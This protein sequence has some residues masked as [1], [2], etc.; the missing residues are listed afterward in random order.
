VVHTT[1]RREVHE[2]EESAPLPVADGPAA[3]L[4]AM[5]SPSDVLRLQ[6]AIG[7]H[8]TGTLLGSRMLLRLGSRLDKPL[9]RGAPKP[10]RE[11]AGQ[12]RRYSVAQYIKMWEREQGRKITPE[13]RETIERGCIGLTADNL[14]GGGNPPL[15]L[16]FSTFE[17][18]HNDGRQEQDDGRAPRDPVRQG[19][20]LDDVRK[21]LLV[22]P[23]PRSEDAQ[24][25]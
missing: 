24:E 4:A 1:G 19:C 20:S 13:D 3:D 9:P 22:E 7:N 5:R 16:V 12:Q 11:I 2:E 6:G 10:Q 14:S 25:G 8:A 23:E 21:A 18:A 15:D 17:Q